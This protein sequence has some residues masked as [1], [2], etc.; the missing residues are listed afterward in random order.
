MFNFW[1]NAHRIGTAVTDEQWL[2]QARI[3]AAAMKVATPEGVA[4]WINWIFADQTPI[5]P[6]FLPQAIVEVGG[7]P[8]ENQIGKVVGWRFD[9]GPTQIVEEWSSY[10]AGYRVCKMQPRG[11]QDCYGFLSNFVA[12]PTVVLGECPF[13]VGSEERRGWLDGLEVRGLNAQLW[14]QV[15]PTNQTSLSQAIR[16]SQ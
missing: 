16:Q 11:P 8:V 13:P 12:K 14:A 3:C 1:Q 6:K 5:D 15:D 10:D 4:F 7:A 2:A 9:G